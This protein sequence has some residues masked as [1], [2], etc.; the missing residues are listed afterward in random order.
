MYEKIYLIQ[1]QYHSRLTYYLLT[2]RSDHYKRVVL[3]WMGLLN[4]VETIT[5]S[6]AQEMAQMLVGPPIPVTDIKEI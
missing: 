2:F 4:L 3:H 5:Y 1:N 6:I